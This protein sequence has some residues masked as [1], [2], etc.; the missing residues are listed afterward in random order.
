MNPELLSR[1]QF[2]F[3]I[4]FHF[5]YPPLSMGVGLILVAMSFLYVRTRDPKWRQLSFFW[6]KIYGLIFA[7]GVATGLVQEFQFGTNWADYSRF[8][9]NIFGSLLAAEGIF[10]F[11]L[12]G[13]F[14]GLM[15]FGG[16]RLGPR[17]WLFSIFM[18]VFGAH[19][20][21]MWIIMANSWM[22]TPAGYELAQTPYGTL[23]FMTSFKEVVFTPSFIPRLLHT[24]VASWLVGA[25]MV[26][27]VSAFYVLKGRHLE[28]AKAAFKVA[29]PVFVVFSILQAVL[30]GAAQAV[31]VTNY[32]PV[33]LAA[34]EGLWNDQACAPLFIV[35][36]VNTTAQTTTGI[37]IPCLL[38]F[39]AYGDI[40]ATVQGLNSFPSDTWAPINLVFQVYHLMIDL[41]GL[42]IAIGLL[43]ALFAVWKQRIWRTRWLLWI[44]VLSIFLTELATL[45]GWWTAEFGR[46]PWIVWNLLHTA[47]AVS[48][49]LVGGQVLLSMLMFVGLYALLFV[50]FIYL[51][52]EKIQHGPEP[53]EDEVA[54]TSLPDTFKDIFR[55][56]AR[57]SSN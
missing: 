20:S 49:N 52:N 14:L 5:I 53:L 50:L 29:L 26:L 32:Q 2:A 3:T 33:K 19:F 6:V 44:L 13:G 39:L 24:W 46:Q 47:D 42:F 34:M 8:V 18:V 43:A 40:N 38:S 9:G 55:R 54:V 41:G 7:L 45:S 25:S 22:Q 51:L 1:L 31:E 57:A 4:S 15:L 16:N 23:A 12:E 28:T 17:L 21:A 35:G 10:A 11:F 30:F 27:S 36:W 56:R 37:K 48:P